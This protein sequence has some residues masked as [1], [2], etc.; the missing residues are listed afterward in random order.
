MTNFRVASV[1]GFGDRDDIA[2]ERDRQQGVMRDNYY[3]EISQS[4]PDQSFAQMGGIKISSIVRA[5]VSK[6]GGK[7]LYYNH[8]IEW[9]MSLEEARQEVCLE[10][11]I[12]D[13]WDTPVTGLDQVLVEGHTPQAHEY[14]IQVS[15]FP[16]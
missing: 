13:G 14:E 6:G 12:P 15:V 2:L 16:E 10:C 7:A 9:G 5:L 11:L 8:Q 3:A 4:I 1:D